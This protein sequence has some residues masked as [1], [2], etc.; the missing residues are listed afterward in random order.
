MSP[1]DDGGA[2][3]TLGEALTTVIRTAADEVVQTRQA[4]VDD[5]PDGVHQHRIRVRRLRSVLAGMRRELDP[6]AARLLRVRFDEWGS[7]LGVVRDLE[8]LADVADD[9]L[10]AQQIDDADVRR[11]LVAG[12]REEYRRAHARLVELAATPRAREREGLL[13]AFAEDPPIVEPAASARDRLAAALRREARRVGKAAKRADGSVEGF[14]AVRKAGRRLRYNAEAVAGA[15]PG[16]FGDELE[17]LADAGDTIHDLLGGHRDGLIF[18]RRLELARSRA[19]RAGEPVAV[20]DDLIAHVAGDDQMPALDDA[21]A[22]VR[23]A[24]RQ[25]A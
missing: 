19:G 13:A 9:A 3:V 12:H 6:A 11:R 7:E 20:Y 16:M 2:A 21:L 15:V 22:K 8:V 17:D 10:T 25:L 23:K 5:E 24:A 18:A 14:H 4:A 1:E